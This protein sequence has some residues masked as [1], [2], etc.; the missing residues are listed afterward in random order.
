MDFQEWT[1]T[2]YNQ[3][4]DEHNQTS[5]YGV[6]LKQGNLSSDYNCYQFFS[7]FS[8]INSNQNQEILKNWVQSLTDYQD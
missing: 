8:R 7:G 6:V 2:K 4:P 3:T 5:H 1:Q